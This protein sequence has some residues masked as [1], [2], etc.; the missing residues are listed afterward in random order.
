MFLCVIE[1]M[2]LEKSLP[3]SLEQNFDSIQHIVP[4]LLIDHFVSMTDP[5]LAVNTDNDMAYHCAF[6]LPAVAL[7]L[8]KHTPARTYICTYIDISNHSMLIQHFSN[9]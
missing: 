7:T 6:S 2:I 8:G 4:K 1:T 5:S 3:S 9:R